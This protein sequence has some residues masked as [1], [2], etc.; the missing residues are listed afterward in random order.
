MAFEAARQH[1]VAPGVGNGL[2]NAACLLAVVLLMPEL[3]CP[4]SHSGLAEDCQSNR[5]GANAIAR[6]AHPHELAALPL[7]LDPAVMIK[8]VLAAMAVLDREND[9]LW[10]VDSQSMLDQ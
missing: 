9:A 4:L 7:P 6:Q 1:S 3:G 8:A 10:R 2:C 5:V